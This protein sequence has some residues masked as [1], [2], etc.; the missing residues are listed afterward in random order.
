MQA[1]P[2]CKALIGQFEGC[3]LIAYPD[4]A[5]PMAR[6]QYPADGPDVSK[7]APWTIGFGATGPGIT[8]GLVWTMAQAEAAFDAHIAQFAAGVTR[9]LARYPT[10]R[11]T[12]GQFDAL[13]SLAYNIGLD[14]NRNGVAEGLG[15][16][17]LFRK[18]V[19]G[20]YA[21]AKAEFA[22]WNKAGGKVMPGLT[23]R[24]AAEAALY[25]S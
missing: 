10:A 7:G 9:L 19:T 8:R 16:S 2:R 12:Q 20:D 3:K 4:P 17:T 13:V 18:H 11:T 25:A 22:K 5:S 14:E 23:R 24:R 1:S 21:A 6:G 15:D